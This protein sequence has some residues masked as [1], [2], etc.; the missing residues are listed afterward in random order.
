[1][2]RPVTA[3]KS[4][5]PTPEVDPRI[6]KQLL[7]AAFGLGNMFRPPPRQKKF[8]IKSAGYYAP[9]PN[10]KM[11]G[12]QYPEFVALRARNIASGKWTR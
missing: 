11:A 4:K 6:F 9:K 2:T 1:M 12:K 5:P 8:N 7:N 3:K 10:P